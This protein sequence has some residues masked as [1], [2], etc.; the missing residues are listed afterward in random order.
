MAIFVGDVHIHML[1]SW[2]GGL[3][4]VDVEG[5]HCWVVSVVR[6]SCSRTKGTCLYTAHASLFQYKEPLMSSPIFSA[7]G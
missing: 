2:F 6:M 7:A 5:R 4:V 3:W 1:E